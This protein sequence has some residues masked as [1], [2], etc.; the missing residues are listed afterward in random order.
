MEI[1]RK[2]DMS[3]AKRSLAN[4]CKI[5]LVYNVPDVEGTPNAYSKEPKMWQ[6]YMYTSNI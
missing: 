5:R 4:M 3:I 1:T 6:V 2:S